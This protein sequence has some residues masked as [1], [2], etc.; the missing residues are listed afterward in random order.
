L[1]ILYRTNTKITSDPY[2][3]CCRI[4]FTSGRPR[5][6]YSSKSAKIHVKKHKWWSWVSQ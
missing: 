6:K 5:P 1:I 4:H 2:I 3:T